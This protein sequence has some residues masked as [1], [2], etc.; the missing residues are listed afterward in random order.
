MT[1]PDFIPAD[2]RARLKAL[3]L[4]SR[5]SAQAQG[6]GLQSSRHLGSGMEFAQYRSYEPGDEPRQ[7]DW[8]LY[9]RSDRFFVREAERDSPLTV[10]LLIDTT[11]SMAQSDAA[12]P[13]WSRL[14]AAR[15]LAACVIELAMRQGDRFGVLSVGGAGLDATDAGTGP[16]QRDRC[17][18]RL[19]ELSAGG[20]WPDE[21]ALRPLWQRVHGNAMVIVLSDGFDEHC[22]ALAERLAKAGREVLHIQILTT[23]ERDFP[24]R[25]G[26]RFRDPETGEELICDGE[27]VREDFIR[28]FAQ[29]R[30]ELSTRLAA[31][32]VGHAEYLLDEPLDAPLR[33]WFGESRRHGAP[34]R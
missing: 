8:K 9:A 3:R 11:A 24:F 30:T 1:P 31:A 4:R 17:L 2:V 29:A 12:R 34:A 13:Q 26:Y 25:G 10:W 21:T 5:R 15:G 19:H 32:G 33:R 7:I 23:D 6:F 16:R 22:V 27:S 14:D 20:Q 28:R 18:M